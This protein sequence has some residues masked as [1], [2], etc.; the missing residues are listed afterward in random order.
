MY[1]EEKPRDVRGM[2]FVNTSFTIVV[3]PTRITGGCI[4]YG[5]KVMIPEDEQAPHQ[6]PMFCKLVEKCHDVVRCMMKLYIRCLYYCKLYL[7]DNRK[8]CQINN[9][10]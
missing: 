9:I 6:K 7:I 4:Q 3:S 5:R 2:Q 8:S 1:T 10:S